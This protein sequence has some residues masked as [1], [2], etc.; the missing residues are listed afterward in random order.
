VRFDL[1]D[2]Q[3]MLRDVVRDLGRG[4]FDD[5]ALE[6]AAEDPTTPART[7]GWAELHALGLTVL[8][9][10]ERHGG[11]GGSVTDLCVVAEALGE[12]L[13]PLPYVAS[14]VA[15]PRLLT[16][17]GATAELESLA[18]G[19]VLAPLVADDLAWP[20]GRAALALDWL[21]G[22]RGV[23]ITPGGAVVADLGDLPEL[24]RTHDPLHPLVAVDVDAPA[25]PVTEELRRARAAVRVAQAAFSL[26]L[27]TAALDVAVAYAKER[28][29]YGRPIGTFQ[30]VQHLCADML[31]DVE[32]SRSIVYGA[33]WAVEHEPVDDAERRAAAAL[34]WAGPAGVRTCE[35]SIQVLGGIGVTREH[36]AHRRLRSAHLFA[37]AFGGAQAATDHLAALRFDHARRK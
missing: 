10:P 13:A 11:T 9:V 31:V 30:A 2:E 14:A 29:Q 8:G 36:A 4:A 22:A 24:V 32:A 3:T 16:A 21:P 6:A 17:V 35:Q 12:C 27:A 23:A 33:S 26:G 7:K 28:E 20:S 5:H 18:D 34:T 25:P 1:T 15:V 37:D 19:A